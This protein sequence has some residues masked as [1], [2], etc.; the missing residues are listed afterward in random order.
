M[1]PR[2]HS[3]IGVFGRSKFPFKL[4]FYVCIDSLWINSI[5][6]CCSIS[7]INTY[8]VVRRQSQVRTKKLFYK[9]FYSIIGLLFYRLVGLWLWPSW[10]WDCGL[11]VVV[12]R[13]CTWLIVCCLCLCLVHNKILELIIVKYQEIPNHRV[14]TLFIIPNPLNWPYHKDQGFYPE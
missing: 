11:C 8:S 2:F 13:V 12:F 14:S 7:P 3:K 1:R 9:T 4:F 10:S 6:C 5:I